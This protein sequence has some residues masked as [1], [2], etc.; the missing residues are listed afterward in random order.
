M[1]KLLA[2][3]LA[4]LSLSGCSSNYSSGFRLGVVRK[5]S[6]RGVFIK[7]W[8][9]QLLLGGVISDRAEHPTLVNETWEFSIDPDRVHGENI[10]EIV[11]QLTKAAE[12]GK[13]TKIYYIQNTLPKIRTD[14][15]YFVQKAEIVG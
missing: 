3:S 11:S 9:G 5:F 4:V 14:T 2:L 13:R 10:E 7:S 12:S 6:N 15:S 8:E 1:K